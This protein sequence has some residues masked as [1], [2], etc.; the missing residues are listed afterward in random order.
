MV[1]H[2]LQQ[3]QSI[4]EKVHDTVDFLNASDSRLKRFGELVSQYNVQDRKLILECKTRWNS[5]YGMLDCALKFRKIFPRYALH[6]HSYKHCLDDDEWGKIE[7]QLEIL[8]VFKATTNI[9]SESEYPASTMF[10]GEVQRIKVLLYSKFE[11]ADDFVKNMVGNI[12]ERFD[13]YWGECNLL[14]AIGLVL[15]PRLKMRA[16]EIAFPKMFPSHLVMENISKVKDIMYQL[17]DEYLTMYSSS[18]NV[19]E[20]EE[21][22]FSMDVHGGDVTSNGLYELLQDVFSGEIY[23]PQVKSKLD[24]YLDEGCIFSQDAKFDVIAWWKE[25]PNKFCILSRM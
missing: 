6:D 4:I 14:M 3:V 9:I 13:K 1:Q 16:V 7:K 19:E 25:K 22:A 15:D 23:V 18:C 11:S 20:S 5:T 10:L 12:K 8:K 2:S 24:S 17:F 21:H